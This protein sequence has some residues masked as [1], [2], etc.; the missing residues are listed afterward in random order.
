M[1]II[2][3][4]DAI[5][6]TILLV[7]FSKQY[8]RKGFIM[9]L[10]NIFI[11]PFKLIFKFSTFV[12]GKILQIIAKSISI[13]FE[14][15]S[16]I[17]KPLSI[18]AILLT[19]VGFINSLYSDLGIKIYILHVIFILLFVVVFFL[20]QVVI[21]FCNY[22]YKFAE[23]IL[24]F[25]SSIELFSSLIKSSKYKTMGVLES[26]HY[27]SDFK[28]TNSKTTNYSGLLLDVPYIEKDEAKKLGAIW[29]PYLKKW[30]TSYR[31]N[32]Y[33]FK[34]W[35]TTND[36]FYLLS[37]HCYLIEGVRKCFKCHRDTKV[38][39]FGIDQ[40]IEY[41]SEYQTGY[42]YKTDNEIHIVSEISPMPQELLDYL[43]SKYNYMLSYS[44]FMQAKYMANHCQHCNA[45]QGNFFLFCEVDSPF[46]VDSEEKAKNLNI[47]KITLEH[48]IAL[49]ELNISFSS[50]DVLI[51][52]LSNQ[53]NSEIVL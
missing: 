14:I 9:I 18:L 8:C 44:N 26:M 5:K 39:C 19:F 4:K 29:N 22:I 3:L 34:R 38:V 7:A 17:V 35:I 2:H 31:K 23:Y 52:H 21:A 42:W 43:Q 11:F 15:G 48:D 37:D 13:I 46:M 10:L 1:V 45:L 27:E 41:N 33:K 30:T 6:I 53:Y 20:P 12:F 36:T 50:G 24:N 49:D 16:C 51:K 25:S 47:H 40:Y 32:Y 28:N